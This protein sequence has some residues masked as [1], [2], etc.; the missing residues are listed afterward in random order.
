MIWAVASCVASDILASYP[1]ERVFAGI[2]I[3]RVAHF[4][5]L[6][7][8][9]VSTQRLRALRL[10]TLLVAVGVLVFAAPWTSVSCASILAPNIFAGFAEK[11][12]ELLL[13]RPSASGMSG[14][15]RASSE[16]PMPSQPEEPSRLPVVATIGQFAG[17]MT[18]TSGVS[19]P[20]AAGSPALATSAADILPNLQCQR[21]SEEIRIALPAP[22]GDRL[23][24]PPCAV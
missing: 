10:G 24:R 8:M 5:R 3:M 21:I 16:V 13:D 11:S 20:G 2:P 12:D 22:P 7:T 15:S 1:T 23:F 4:A 14:A 18:S 6:L 9:L 19:A 17:G